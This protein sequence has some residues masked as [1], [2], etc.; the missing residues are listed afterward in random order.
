MTSYSQWSRAA[1]V[2]RALSLR[3]LVD[4][5]AATVA[6]VPQLLGAEWA[7]VFGARRIVSV[8]QLEVT[9][10]FDG[11]PLGEATLVTLGGSVGTVQQW[12]AH[13]AQL[14]SGQTHLLFVRQGPLGR[15]WVSGMAQGAYA[16]ESDVSE[17]CV[18]VSPD[19][20]EFLAQPGSAAA[21]LDGLDSAGVGRAIRAVRE[22]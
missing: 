6:A 5:S 22:S 7:D 12:V 14:S 13:E 21:A 15:L 3:Q 11:E 19:Q 4:G 20:A 10:V 2:T 18:R 16:T 8:W 17:W 9:E 1:P